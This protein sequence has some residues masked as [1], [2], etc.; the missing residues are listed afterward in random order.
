ML[1]GIGTPR[2]HLEWRIALRLAQVVRVPALMVLFAQLLVIPAAPAGAAPPVFYPPVFV[3]SSGD[4]ID[5]GSHSSPCVT[6]WDGDG[7]KDLILG[8]F[9]FG[10]IR[11]Y[12][13]VGTNDSPLF[14]GYTLM[15]ADGEPILLPY[16]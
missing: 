15:C 9:D 3:E 7:L 5:V 8:Q 6:D 12:P 14:E 13:N 2:L 10:M 4:R 16:G 11:F 1:Q